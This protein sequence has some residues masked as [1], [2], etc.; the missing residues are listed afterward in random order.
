MDPLDLSV[1]MD[2]LCKNEDSDELTRGSTPIELPAAA[3]SSTSINSVRP[4]LPAAS[5][6]GSMPG[7]NQDE[8]V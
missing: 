8:M 1:A 6:G 4:D 3:L 2:G 5:D 7:T